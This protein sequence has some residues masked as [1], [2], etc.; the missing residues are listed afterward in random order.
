MKLYILMYHKITEPGGESNIYSVNK[1]QFKAQMRWLKGNNFY[2]VTTKEITGIKEKARDERAAMVTFDDG[3]A[4]N[5]FNAM[6]ILQEFGIKATFFLTTGW[7]GREAMMTWEQ[8]RR[9]NREGM[10]IESHACSHRFLTDLNEEDIKRELRDSKEV[11]ENEIG[12]SCRYISCPGGRINKKIIGIAK[13]MGFKGIFGSMPGLNESNL[14]GNNFV[15]YKRIPLTKNYTLN[16]F[17]KIFGK[18]D[19]GFMIERLG[20]QLK[21]LLK[22]LLGDEIYQQAWKRLINK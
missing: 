3:Y 20:Y 21:N 9:M 15:V 17:K 6:P 16:N 4:D 11:I 18:S 1:E 7:I 10:A 14:L 13:E 22:V 8:L 5:Y 12:N 2:C 19:K